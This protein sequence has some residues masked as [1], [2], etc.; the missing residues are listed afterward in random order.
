MAEYRQADAE[1]QLA[2]RPMRSVDDA[3]KA[4]ASPG[5]CIPVLS[6]NGKCCAVRMHGELHTLQKVVFAL[7]G[8][9]L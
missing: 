5:K 1:W 6:L 2:K 8:L 4:Q 7:M 3:G 9:I